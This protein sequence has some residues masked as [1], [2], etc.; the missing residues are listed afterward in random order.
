METVTAPLRSSEVDEIDSKY[1]LGS[2][3]ANFSS[4]SVH[5]TLYRGNPAIIRIIR[6]VDSAEAQAF[7]EAFALAYRLPHSNLLAIYDFGVTD[8][9]V[10]VVT[11]RPDE[12]LADILRERVLTEDETRE[13][14]TG[15]LPAIEFLSDRRLAPAHLDPARVFACGERVKFYP[16]LIEL[17]DPNHVS[18]QLA[19]LLLEAR[20]GSSDPKGVAALNAPFREWVTG[21]WSP[22]QIRR[23][24]AGEP[25]AV[26][27]SLPDQSADP[28]VP[29]PVVTQPVVPQPRYRK[30]AGLAIGGALAAA[31]L[32]A[33]LVR[34]AH[35]SALVQ[36]S[37]LSFDAQTIAATTPT[38]VPKN[39][40]RP[41]S[42]P[43]VR[44]G[45][46]I[47]GGNYHRE[48]DA[49]K[50][51]A[52]IRKEHPKLDGQV[53]SSQNGSESR[54]V[55]LFASGL[56]ETQAKKQLARLRRAGAPRDINIT[57][58]K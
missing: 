28:L 56:T 23:S 9:H 8:T 34:G 2:C 44:S 6:G 30:F 13:L 53:F 49:I 18:S 41:N 52:A 45:W 37:P 22:E 50:H 54:F 35:N 39:G 16:E 46:A 58:F 51:L 11:E 40:T 15:L 47:T 7:N 32:C 26:E 48:D 38:P 43:T 29:Q 24:L 25:V 5:E 4:E 12:R 57:R 21:R 27:Q 17:N 14:L 36:T 55:I 33:L 42:Y 1:P 10:W 19:S 31:A 20:T 3:L